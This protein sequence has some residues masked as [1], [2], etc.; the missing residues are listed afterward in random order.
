MTLD[1][2]TTMIEKVIQEDRKNPTSYK[3]LVAIGHTK[4]LGDFETIENILG[5]LG[6]RNIPVCTLE[7]VYIKCK[8]SMPMLIAH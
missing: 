2:L 1:E 8:C 7:D 5:Y 3:P 6:R 4:D